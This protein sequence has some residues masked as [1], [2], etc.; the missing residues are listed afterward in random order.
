ME[1]RGIK[2]VVVLGLLAAAYGL[3]SWLVGSSPQV[4]LA[5]GRT[6]S[7]GAVR[8]P[9]RA[10]LVA[11]QAPGLVL[12][13]LKLLDADG[14]AIRAVTLSGGKQP[15]AKVTIIDER[16]TLLHTGTFRYG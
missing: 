2:I 4:M 11:N 12:F 10:G 8:T 16:G 14:Q 7:G 9:I 13:T 15:E 3:Y 1:N 6:V 5:N